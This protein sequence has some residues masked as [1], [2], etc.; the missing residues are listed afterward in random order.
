MDSRLRG[1]DE[2]LRIDARFLEVT[3]LQAHFTDKSFPHPISSSAFT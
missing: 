3:K 2:A 1:N